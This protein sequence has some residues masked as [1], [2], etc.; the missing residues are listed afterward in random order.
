M[1]SH[2]SI[3]TYLTKWK[4]RPARWWITSR[5]QA[6]DLPKLNN[7]NITLSNH[8]LSETEQ[9]K[10]DTIKL[11]ARASW[12]N[13]TNREQHKQTKRNEANHDMQQDSNAKQSQQVYHL[14]LQQTGR[15]SYS[16]EADKN[17]ECTFSGAANGTMATRR[18][19]HHTNPARRS[20]QS[21][22]LTPFPSFFFRTEN[23]R[24]VR[25]LRTTISLRF[26]F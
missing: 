5:Y 2:S 17:G 13:R 6:I 24:R 12:R 18:L 22:D 7:L 14:I 10:T 15:I 20:K 19:F 9:T 3:S 4:R 26:L 8:R 25:D 23:Q 11:I 1:Y 21:N 16:M